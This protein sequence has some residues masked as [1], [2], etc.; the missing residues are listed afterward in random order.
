MTVERFNDIVFFFK[1][2]L[3]CLNKNL[4]AVGKGNSTCGILGK[5]ENLAFLAEIAQTKGENGK[6]GENREKKWEGRK[7]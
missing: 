3:V 4:Q 6:R 7:M 1:I 2:D 5:E